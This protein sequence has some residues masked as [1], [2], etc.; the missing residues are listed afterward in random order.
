M[1]AT[2]LTRAEELTNLV[3]ELNTMVLS[4][5]L[6]EAHDKF[7]ADNCIQMENPEMAFE[8]KAFNRA[9]EEE[10]LN[11]VT[12]FRGAEVK[13]IAIDAEND[14]TMVEWFMDYSHKEWGDKTYNQVSVARWEGDKIVHERYYNGG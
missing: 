5:Q 4:G 3:T 11:N 1:E 6:L 2:T 10:W 9:R 7:Y 12:E 13:S 14:V 8:G